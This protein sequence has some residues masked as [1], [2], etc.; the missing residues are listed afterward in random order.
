MN[1]FVC[2]LEDFAEEETHAVTAYSPEHAAAL[3]A[4]WSDAQAGE[5]YSSRQTVMV[6]VDGKWQPHTVEATPTVAYV[7][8]GSKP[9]VFSICPKSHSG[10]GQ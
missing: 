8:P 2:R 1:D 5:G 3:Y 9:P 4:Q 7:V 10:D 6:R